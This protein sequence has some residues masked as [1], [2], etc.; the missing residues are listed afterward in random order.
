MFTTSARAHTTF[1]TRVSNVDT[2]GKS[3]VVWEKLVVGNIH[4][5]KFRGKNFSS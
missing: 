3:T 2:E 4:E 5:K 1:V